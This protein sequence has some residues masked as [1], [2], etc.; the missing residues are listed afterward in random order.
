[1]LGVVMYKRLLVAS[2]LATVMVVGAAGAAD[3]P[4]KGP[5]YK[6]PVAAPF[7]WTGFYVGGHVGYGWGDKDW[8]HFFDPINPLN[9]VPGPDT[10]YHVNGFLGGGQIRYTWPSGCTVFGF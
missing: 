9:T 4:T 8:S 6:A 1:M 5:V 7:S 2:A 10:R 3:L